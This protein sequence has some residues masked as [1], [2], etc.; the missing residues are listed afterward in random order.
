M[1]LTELGEF[2]DGLGYKDSAADGAW[3]VV[4]RG[5]MPVIHLWLQ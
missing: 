1:P 2:I 4:A 5:T 3:A